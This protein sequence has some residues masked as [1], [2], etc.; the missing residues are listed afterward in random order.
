MNR[1]ERLFQMMQLLRVLPA[2][3]TAEQVA[4]DMSVSLRTV[5][6]DIDSLRSLG[7]VI[8]GEAGFGYTLIEDASLPPLNFEDDEIEALVLGLRDVSRIGD[9][10]LA[11]AARSSLAKLKARLPP[12]Q[13][14][15]LEHAVLNIRR[16]RNP[17]D[18]TVD[19]AK[20]R[21]ATWKEEIVSF[22]YRDGSGASTERRVKP[23]GIVFLDDCH[24]LLSWCLLRQDFRN[25]RLDRMSDLLTTGDHFRPNRVPLLRDAVA[26]VR[27]QTDRMAK[28]RPHSE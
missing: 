9:P 12:R 16:F 23:L 14:H 13:S 19:V 8:D 2:P 27:G 26:L 18:P 10:A 15:R 4:I 20:L 1:T 17:P 11:K 7:A 5:Y 25:F 3:V 24:M 22:S 6:R 21:S 28:D